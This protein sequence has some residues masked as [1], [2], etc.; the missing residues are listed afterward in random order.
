MRIFSSLWSYSK[1][2]GVRRKLNFPRLESILEL[3][4][5]LKFPLLGSINR[6]VQ[7][8]LVDILSHFMVFLIKNLNIK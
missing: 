6:R 2:S 8:T 4:K 5:I 7:V 1:L 3:Y